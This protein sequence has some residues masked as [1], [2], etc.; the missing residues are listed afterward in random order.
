VAAILL[1]VSPVLTAGAW[2]ESALIN[3]MQKQLNA[4][5]GLKG[6]VSVS[7]LAGL[8]G[9]SLDA[10]YI[11]Q[12]EQSQLA[13]SLKNGGGEMAK[14]ALY[15]QDGALAL[16]AFLTSGKLYSITGGWESLLNRI[17]A[18]ETN[19][20]QTSMYS[21]LWS[22]LSPGNE[23][24]A[25]KLNEAAAP[26]LT[27][28]DLW[29]QGF[30]EP[31][32]LEKDENGV[33]FMKGVYH[34]PAAALKAELKQLMVDLL[35]DKTL[36]PLLWSKMTQ[37]QANLYLNPAL[38]SFYFTA[39]DT[40]PLQGE[41]TMLRRV[42]TTGQLLETS[43]TLP[44]N[45]TAGGMEQMSFTSKAVAGG[46]LLD[47]TLTAEEGSLQITA[48]KPAAE[49]PGT[50]SYSGIIRYL[51]AQ[52]PNWQVDSVTPQYMGKALS[53]S[54]RAAYVTA[55]STDADGKSIENYTLTVSLQPDWSHLTQEVTDA[56]KAQYVLTDPVQLTGTVIFSSGQARNASTS[57]AVELHVVSGAADWKINGQFKTTPPWNFNQVDITAAEKLENMSTEQ[58]SVLLTDFLSKPGLLPLITNLMP[59]D[60]N[61]PDTVG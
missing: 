8:E 38:Q 41:I 35:A 11:Q 58:L 44:L 29:M 37:D 30:A 24:E 27:K 10:Q 13:L 17:L 43:L 28:I 56:I 61:N 3:K 48:L 23:E 14:L 55:L 32:A 46:N 36:L 40:L 25:A 16:N 20:W 42:T 53:V 7:G 12:K 1:A 47:C 26:Y 19:G 60:Q 5:S 6:T 31:S 59:L 57:L 9:L 21:A 4:G 54:Y 39:V 2:A 49:Q 18:G 15:E 50:V 45:G 52:M 22:I 33:S 34:I 51:P